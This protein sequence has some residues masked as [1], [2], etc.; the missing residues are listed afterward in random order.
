LD[1]VEVTGTNFTAKLATRAIKVQEKDESSL[2][3]HY[4]I[5]SRQNP[6]STGQSQSSEM[7]K[8]ENENDSD[9]TPWTVNKT[10]SMAD[11]VGLS[12]LSTT[13]MQTEME[14]MAQAITK[15]IPNT[16]ENQAFLPQFSAAPFPCLRGLAALQTQQHPGASSPGQSL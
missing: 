2:F 13:D 1:F 10:L 11:T 3:P 4:T 14:L 9:D 7:Y 12:T 6:S 8:E 15:F 16:P 5:A